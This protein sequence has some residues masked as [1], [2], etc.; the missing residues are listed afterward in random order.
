MLKPII[1]VLLLP[2]PITIWIIS[3][4]PKQEAKRLKR[5]INKKKP[6]AWNSLN[7]LAI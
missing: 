1:S 7:L 5:G 3:N 2:L 4:D 6:K